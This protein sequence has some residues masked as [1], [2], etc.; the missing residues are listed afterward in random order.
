[1]IRVLVADDHPIVLE[2]MR[3][4]LEPEGDITVVAM[5]R[6]GEEALRLCRDTKPDVAVLDLAMP[7]LDGEEVTARLVMDSS[8]TKI[9]ILT[10]YDSENHAIHVLQAGAAGFIPKGA[11]ADELPDAIRKVHA[12]GTYISPSILEK[13]GENIGKLDGSDPVSRLSERELQVL[14]HLAAGMK[15]SEIAYE[16]HL[17]ISTIHSYRYRMMRKLGLNS[18][19]ALIRFAFEKGVVR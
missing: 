5:A 13:I 7:R 1:M 15:T 2:G 14:K 16:L 19:A 18:N 12:G 3:R 10:M 11:S 9:I 4:M 8:E 17:S 6:D